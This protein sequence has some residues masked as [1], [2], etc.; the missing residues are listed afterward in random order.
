MKI[1]N[2]IVGGFLS[3]TFGWGGITPTYAANQNFTLVI[4]AGHGGKDVGAVDNNQREKDINLGVAQKL[5]E[6]IRANMKDVKVVLTRD[7]DRFLTLKERADI[8]NSNKGNLFISIHTNSVDASNPGRQK[9]SGASVY[10][11]GL[12]KDKSNLQVA[13]RENAVIELENNFVQKYSGFDPSKDE[14]YIIFEMAQKKNLGQ[15]LKYAELAQK[16]LVAE[17]GRADR[18]VK[19]AGFWVLWATSM[20]AVLVELDFICN[21]NA[22]QYMGSEKGQMQLATALYKGFESYLQSSGARVEAV[23]LPEVKSSRMKGE[24]PLLTGIQSDTTK[25]RR[26]NDE[27][28]RNSDQRVLETSTIK[29][30]RETDLIA[31]AESPAEDLKV[32][33]LAS[34]AGKGKKENSS[35]KKKKRS[36][37]VKKKDN[38][39]NAG[40]VLASAER[41][42]EGNDSDSKF[43]QSRAAVQDKIDNSK[44]TK[45]LSQAVWQSKEESPTKQTPLIEGQTKKD[46]PNNTANRGN[47]VA[48]H[49]EVFKI[50]LLSS[51]TFLRMNN[52]EFRGLAPVKSFRDGDEYKYTYGESTNREEIEKLLQS[53]RKLIP[54]ATIIS[55]KR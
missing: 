25:R 50:L 8:A 2:I 39:G 23:I 1:R 21:P 33:E 14:S 43:S 19:Q 36:S 51:K 47:L 4:D 30:R 20:P 12:H 45:E 7:D 38:T 18:G 27:A 28:R 29:V 48:N 3:L 52:P 32:R 54:S 11:L 26:R 55:N 5:A 31:Q 35:D 42:P 22:A 40:A 34:Y 16:N 53:V 6:M 15:S 10:A 17:A 41:K 37:S 44:Q 9:V 24:R 46:T 49:A 13:M